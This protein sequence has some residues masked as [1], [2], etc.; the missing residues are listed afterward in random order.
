MVVCV[1][2]QEIRLLDGMKVKHAL[3]QTRLLKD[4]EKGK[5]VYDEWGNE[6]GLSGSLWDGAYLN[7][8]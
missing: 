6:M 2:G 5:K 7:V 4:V 1:A 8:R 3:I